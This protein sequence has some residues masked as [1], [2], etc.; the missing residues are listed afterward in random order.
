MR[1]NFIIF[2]NVKKQYTGETGMEVEAADWENNILTV[3]WHVKR[4]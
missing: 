4:L 1:N 2:L 3:K